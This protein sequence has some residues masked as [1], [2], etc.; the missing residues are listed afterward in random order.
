[1][2]ANIS[3]YIG[4]SFI[5]GFC[6]CQTDIYALEEPSTQWPSLTELV[7]LCELK[8]KHAFTHEKQAYICPI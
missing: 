6:R 3:E 4:M 1:M 2:R 5:Q 8:Q 7:L